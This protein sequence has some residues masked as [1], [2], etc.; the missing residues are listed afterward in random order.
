M[1]NGEWWR[2][3]TGLMS[4]DECLKSPTSRGKCVRACVC[5]NRSLMKVSSQPEMLFDGG[6]G[7]GGGLQAL[8]VLI[9]PLNI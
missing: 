2:G 6:G 9:I 8:W 7:G 5:L 4:R 3:T 1:M